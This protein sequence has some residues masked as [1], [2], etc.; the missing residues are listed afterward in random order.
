MESI[1]HKMETMVK[2]KMSAIK[3]AEDL[4]MEVNKFED[5]VEEFEYEIRQKEKEISILEEELDDT[6]TA[7]KEA[8]EK[9]MAVEM[10]ATDSELEAQALRGRFS[11]CQT[12]LENIYFFYSSFFDTFFESIRN[13]FWYKSAPITKNSTHRRRT[14]TSNRTTPRNHRQIPKNRSRSR[15]KPT[16]HQNQ[17]SNLP[18]IRRK[19]GTDLRPK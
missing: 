9:V 19:T 16:R 12:F 11:I 13:K 10:K 5:D 6:L 1:K 17:R 7:T 4:E 18:R 8:L 2:E 15:R 14:R 3:I